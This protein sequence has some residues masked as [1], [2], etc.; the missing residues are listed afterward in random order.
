MGL[1]VAYVITL[2]VTQSIS[3]G[4]GLAVDRYDSSDAGL[5]AFL[6]LYFLMF[7]LSWQIA[8]L[9][10]GAKRHGPGFLTRAS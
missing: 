5:L 3:I 9:G 1:I 10:D 4:V 6:G 8:I 2:A 7:W